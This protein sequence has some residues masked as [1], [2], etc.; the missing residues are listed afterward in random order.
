MGQF[1][2]DYS[3]SISGSDCTL[4]GDYYFE[5]ELSCDSAKTEDCFL[6]AAG[7]AATR[8]TKVTVGA[9]DACPVSDT[10]L[11]SGFDI[12]L[13]VLDE[14]CLPGTPPLAFLADGT[15]CLEISATQAAFGFPVTDA[16]ISLVTDPDMD[17]ARPSGTTAEDFY[18]LPP[19]MGDDDTQV[20]DLSEFSYVATNSVGDFY[21]A[22]VLNVEVTVLYENRARDLRSTTYSMPTV[23][24]VDRRDNPTTGDTTTVPMSGAPKAA[25][26]ASGEATDGDPI[27]GEH[28]VKV[29]LIL[30]ASAVLVAAIVA[31]TV[32]VVVRHNRQVADVRINVAHLRGSAAV[33]QARRDHEAKV[34]SVAYDASSGAESTA[35]TVSAATLVSASA[36][37]LSTSSP[38][39][40]SSSS[41]YEDSSL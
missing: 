10:S 20:L 9:A 28:Y 13:T 7:Q 6:S 32:C 21:E 34:A 36:S 1:S 15:V 19:T 41:S 12:S 40:S 18:V 4:S 14:N 23:L 30:G 33:E 38:S 22:V 24:R 5:Y 27:S 29:S 37:S 3:A 25:A 26:L 39:S 31:V 11:S 2:A 17:E 16:Y 35:A 8:L